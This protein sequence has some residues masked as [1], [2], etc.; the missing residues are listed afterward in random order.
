VAADIPPPPLTPL[1]DADPA[2][3]NLSLTAKNA[4]NDKRIR[5]ILLVLAGD[6]PTNVEP[7]YGGQPTGRPQL[8]VGKTVQ[9]DAGRWY[10]QV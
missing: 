1:T 9:S 7:D 3:T 4:T 10:V 2:L 6:P 8:N 5:E